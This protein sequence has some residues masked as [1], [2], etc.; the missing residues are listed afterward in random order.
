MHA[1]ACVTENVRPPT[2]I[3]AKRGPPPVL[4]A[5]EYVT[6]PFP[7]PF[8][9]DVTVNHPASLLAVHVQPVPVDTVKLPDP[10]GEAIEAFV[11]LKL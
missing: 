5:A 6:E 3:P 7:L 2:L 8:G 1:T 9:L 10:P 11:G 4:A